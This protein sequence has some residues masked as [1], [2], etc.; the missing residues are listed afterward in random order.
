LEEN[1]IGQLSK[2]IPPEADKLERSE[3]PRAQR[4]GKQIIKSSYH[5]IS[6]SAYQHIITSAHHHISTSS[7]HHISTSSHHHISTSDFP[8]PQRPNRYEENLLGQPISTNQQIPPEADKLERSEI[9][10]ANHHIII[11]AHQHI[12]TSSHQHISTSAHQHII[13]SAHQHIRLP[14]SIQ[15]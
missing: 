12:S 6:I 13:T 2:Q 8:T 14:Y 3:I 11:S 9:R 10:E 5:H 4:F 1:L 15:T 7:H